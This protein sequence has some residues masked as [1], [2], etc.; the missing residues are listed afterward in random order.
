M[1]IR[2]PGVER[3]PQADKSRRSAYRRRTSEGADRGSEPVEGDPPCKVK[4]VSVQGPIPAVLHIVCL[5][6]MKAFPKLST[7]TLVALVF[8]FSRFKFVST[9][10][11]EVS[12][13]TKLVKTT[14]NQ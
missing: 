14:I 13:T 4:T 5:V 10:T 1:Q 12:Q 6:N 9:S 2:V 3:F 7:K 8:K 11:G